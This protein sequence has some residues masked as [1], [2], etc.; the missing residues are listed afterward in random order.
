MP[1]VRRNRVILCAGVGAVLAAVMAVSSFLHQIT[2]AQLDYDSGRY[3]IWN[4]GSAVCLSWRKYYPPRHA[5]PVENRFSIPWVAAYYSH[6]GEDYCVFAPTLQSL[7]VLE[8]RSVTFYFWPVV[9]YLLWVPLLAAW[10][11]SR[12][13]DTVSTGECANCE[14]DLRGSQTGRCPEC[15]LEDAIV[16]S[17]NETGPVGD[18]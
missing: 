13:D 16:H 12:T 7:P 9:V 8:S 14:Y 2:I 3:A 6:S 17:T 15:G 5:D 4:H 1:R 10:R 11:W 18:P